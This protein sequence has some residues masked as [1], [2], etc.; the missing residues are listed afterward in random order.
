M[1]VGIDAANIR[2]GGG[3]THLV[4][5]LRSANP[6]AHG[7]S[8]VVVWG[9]R[10]TLDR[11]D[12]R[13][14]LIK[15]HQPM[16][17]KSIVFRIWWQ[18][19]RLSNLA[20][21]GGCNVLYIPGGSFMGAFRPIVA[22][23]QNLLPFEWREF[24]RYGW[25]VVT[26]KMMLLRWTQ[27]RTF[28]HSDGLILLTAYAQAA[29]IRVTKTTA[30]KMTI[31]PHGVDPRFSKAPREQ[32]PLSDYSLDHP[33][34]ILYVSVVDVYK[35]QWHVAEAVAGLRASGLPLALDLVGPAYPPA[36]ER[37]RNT[38]EEIDPSERFVRYL[39]PIPH[40]VLHEWYSQADVCLFASSCETFGQILIEAM[41][42]GLPIACS[43]RSAMPELLGDAGVYFDPEDPDDIAR[44]ITELLASAELRRKLASASFSRAQ[45]YSWSRCADETFKF[46]AEVAASTQRN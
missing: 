17:D 44:A 20:R 38:Q 11:I 39:G 18:R 25:S 26:A 32:K 10:S 24:R 41:A 16:L 43:N 3:V 21:A 29:V 40:G 37:L 42:A 33:L 23:S 2:G 8:E 5:L 13:E 30:P 46:L 7:F 28:R 19:F 14:W 12:D 45:V 35:H 15:S 31:I 22:F 27:S 36:L 9:G 6:A 4:E 1:I 34:R